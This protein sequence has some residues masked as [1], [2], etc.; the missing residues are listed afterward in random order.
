MA[1]REDQLS[2]TSSCRQLTALRRR[3]NS[4]CRVL[5]FHCQRYILA[6]SCRSRMPG[7][8][9]AEWSLA[10]ANLRPALRSAPSHPLG[11]GCAVPKA[12]SSCMWREKELALSDPTTRIPIGRTLD[13][14]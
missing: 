2:I 5:L 1:A 11:A 10:R 3:Q 14:T 13:A 9:P 8:E 4:G 6:E 12:N 7:D